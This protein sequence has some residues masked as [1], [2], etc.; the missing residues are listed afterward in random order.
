[1]FYYLNDKMKKGGPHINPTI[2]K[3]L[4]YYNYEI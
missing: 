4:P 3:L 2:V 1:M